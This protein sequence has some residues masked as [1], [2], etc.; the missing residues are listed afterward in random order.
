MADPRPPIAKPTDRQ[1][2]PRW[3]SLPRAGRIPLVALF[4]LAVWQLAALVIGNPILLA[5]PVAVFQA[6]L[7]LV[8][9]W[10]FWASL[11]ATAARILVGLVLGMALGVAL[12]AVTHLSRIA[13]H[14]FTPAV[15][16]LQA[17]PVAA[18]A[19][20]VLIWSGPTIL[21]AAV[22]VVMTLPVA[23]LAV[24]AGLAARDPELIE[25]A[26]VF[27]ATRMQRLRAVAVPA[28]LP[29]L[30]A[31]TQTAIGLAWKAGVSAEVIGLP[32]GS[33]GERLYF[34]RLT[35]ATDELL[36]WTLVIVAA[37][38]VVERSVRALLGR[39]YGTAGLGP[40]PGA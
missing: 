20:L 35:L 11:G 18:F 3:Y 16:A 34:T 29:F 14:V 31:A 13:D 21:T 40:K 4:W 28:V 39:I 23:F 12:A 32:R 5:S 7:R 33:V 38:L 36:A 8:P 1:G 30:F 9:T 22:V 17:V 6:L 37:S 19:I 15:K 27:G 24:R 26:Q 10:G 25:V 2:R